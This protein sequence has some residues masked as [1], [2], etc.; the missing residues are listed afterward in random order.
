MPCLAFQMVA[1]RGDHFLATMLVASG[2][3][4]CFNVYPSSA[5]AEKL[6]NPGLR[7][8][9]MFLHLGVG[10]CLWCAVEFGGQP[11]VLALGSFHLWCKV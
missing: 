10:G 8:V 4:G 2:R 7:Q 6:E 11:Q 5:C 1:V 3:R 9:G